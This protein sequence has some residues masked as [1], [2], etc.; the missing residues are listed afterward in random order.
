MC[1]A[2]T[3]KTKDVY[4]GRTLDIEC[5]FGEE[6]ISITGVFDGQADLLFGVL[7]S[8]RELEIRAQMPKSMRPL[9]N[10]CRYVFCEGD[11]LRLPKEQQDI[12]RVM[13]EAGRDGQAA[14]RFDAGQSARV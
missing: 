11:V 12:V 5:S 13:L 8:G 3:Y 6:V 4:F 7:R 2:I 9:D 10:Q 14:F 1:T